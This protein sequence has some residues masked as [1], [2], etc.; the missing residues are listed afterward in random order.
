MQAMI[1]DYAARHFAQ[2]CGLPVVGTLGVLA[3]ARQN[4]LLDKAEPVVQGMRAAGIFFGSELVE[5]F[6]KQLGER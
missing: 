4:G 6:L 3:L 5:R 2:Q 1:D